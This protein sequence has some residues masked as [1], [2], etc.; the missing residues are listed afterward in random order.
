MPTGQDLAEPAKA[1]SG[2]G[3]YSPLEPLRGGGWLSTLD[4]AQ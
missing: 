2:G 3:V 1:G 4:L